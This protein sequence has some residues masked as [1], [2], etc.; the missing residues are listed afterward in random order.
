MS[1]VPVSSS[2]DAVALALSQVQTAS[3]VAAL[4]VSQDSAV[5][6]QAVIAASGATASSPAVQV[7][8]PTGTSVDLAASQAAVG[9]AINI[10]I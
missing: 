2:F 10:A 3:T 6:T 1:I 8:S 9:N 7:Y 4:A 5:S